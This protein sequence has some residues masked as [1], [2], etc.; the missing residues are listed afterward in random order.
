MHR[1]PLR[2]VV[3]FALIVIAA[4]PVTAEDYR[5]PPKKVVDIV[6]AQPAPW[7][8]FSPDRKW[9]VWT[10]R[11]ALPSIEDVSRRM[12]R[13]AGMR[14]DPVTNS[15]FRTSFD[16]GFEIRSVANGELLTRVML[17]DGEGIVGQH[18]ADADLPG[19][20]DQP[21]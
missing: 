8:S 17:E 13:L 21:S 9:M 11:D 5:L 19:L 1:Y 16:R 15:R 3:L 6:T 10:H 4:L 20:A 7:V 14:V 12:L 2:W 18:V